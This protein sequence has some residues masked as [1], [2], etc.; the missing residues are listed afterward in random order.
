MRAKFAG[1]RRARSRRLMRAKAAQNRRAD[2]FRPMFARADPVLRAQAIPSRPS[3]C[4]A[5]WREVPGETVGAQ[6]RATMMQS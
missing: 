4:R 5:R 1:G 6:V 2:S 3:R